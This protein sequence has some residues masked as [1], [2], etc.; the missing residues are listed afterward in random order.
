MLYEK[1]LKGLNGAVDENVSSSGVR[2]G[3]AEEVCRF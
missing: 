2:L 1:Y 3:A